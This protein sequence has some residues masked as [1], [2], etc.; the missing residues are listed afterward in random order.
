MEL[1]ILIAT[2]RQGKIIN[3]LSWLIFTLTTLCV[4]YFAPTPF[5]IIAILIAF[6][7]LITQTYYAL[8]IH[9][10][11]ELF[12]LLQNAEPTH[13]HLKQLDEILLKHQLIKK[14]DPQNIRSLE[15]RIL[16]TMKL[17]KLQ[18]IYLALQIVF[19]ILALIF[20]LLF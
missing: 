5:A 11:Y 17:I 6:V 13:E 16:G 4:G 1:S 2:L 15:S 9:F 20:M 14:L 18:I 10:D 8:R 3:G 12:K 7:L 19:Y